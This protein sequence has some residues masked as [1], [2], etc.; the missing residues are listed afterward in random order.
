MQYELKQI[1]YKDVEPYEADYNRRTNDK[2]IPEN[3]AYYGVYSGSTLVSYFAVSDGIE[4]S[5]FIQRG[6]VLPE[7]RATGEVRNVSLKLLEQAAKTAGYS[8]I[9]FES[10]R[11]PWAYARM[12]KSIGYKTRYIG[13]RKTL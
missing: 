4:N 13:F 1:T 7:C 5:L 11:N 3:V 9:E 2:E 12:F 10:T 6:Y 8:S